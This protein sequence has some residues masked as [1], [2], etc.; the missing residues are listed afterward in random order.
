MM[1]QHARYMAPV[2]GVISLLQTLR[3]RAGLHLLLFLVSQLLLRQFTQCRAQA[4]QQA[5]ISLDIGHRTH[6]LSMTRA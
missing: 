2:P 5:T 6:C 1:L 4:G 3:H